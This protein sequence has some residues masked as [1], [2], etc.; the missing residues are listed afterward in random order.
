MSEWIKMFKGVISALRK[1]YTHRVAL[2]K[3]GRKLGVTTSRLLRH[4]NSKFYPVEFFSYVARFEL[5]AWDETKWQ[6]AWKHHWQ[7]NDHHIEYWQEKDLYFS[8]S[9][10][11]ATKKVYAEHPEIIGQPT[12]KEWPEVWMPDAAI[13]EM[14]ADWMAASY[15][16]SGEWPNAG[17][18][19]WGNK[20]LVKQLLKLEHHP[21]PEISSRGFAILLLRNNNLITDEQILEVNTI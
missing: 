3:A 14:I 21:Q 5:G 15:A 8:W 18:W 7:H 16:Y 4:D 17:S 10:G 9:H 11:G 20:Y 1:I 2:W 12:K 13:R 6:R 19:D